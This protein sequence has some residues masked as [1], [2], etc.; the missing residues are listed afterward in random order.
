M[1]TYRSPAT[2][3]FGAAFLWSLFAHQA[4]AF[5]V[6]NP[7]FATRSG[8]T[9]TSRVKAL[10]SLQMSTTNSTMGN[11]IKLVGSPVKNE[12][13]TH[14][15]NGPVFA[16]H[17]IGEFL[18]S[19]E[20]TEENELVVVKFHAKWCKVCARAILKYKKMALKYSSTDTQTPVPIKFVSVESSTNMPIIE[21]LGVKKFPYIQIYRNR[22]CVASFGT[23]PAH[24]FQRMVG[25]T[26][27][28]KLNTP[29]SEWEAFRSE[30]KNEISE[31]LQNLELLR[32]QAGQAA[33]DEECEINMTDN[34]VTP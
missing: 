27:E 2:V 15:P 1:V 24:N 19:V 17:S 9:T 30:F 13:P 7:T 25:S 12:M 4:L 16:V 22:E 34:C 32:L 28:Q 5:T 31:G 8:A 11:G 29:V 20:N 3:L 18:N 26:V 21:Q 10:S 6:Q 23:G 33:L 14:D